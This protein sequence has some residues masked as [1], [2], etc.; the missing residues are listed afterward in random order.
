M[1]RLPGWQCRNNFQY[2]LLTRW[3][4]HAADP[5][6]GADSILRALEEAAPIIA[7][8]YTYGMISSARILAIAIAYERQDAGILA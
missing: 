2:C 6:F 8:E 1:C 5:A 7:R 3:K 4:L